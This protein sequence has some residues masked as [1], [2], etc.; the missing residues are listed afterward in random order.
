[1]FEET[2]LDKGT[3]RILNPNLIDYKWRVFPEL[4]VFEN[5][6]LESEI[7]THRF[8]A[9]GVGEIATAPGPSAVLMAVSNAIGKRI[10]VYPAT[11]ERILKA[12]GKI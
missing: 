1:M 11:P 2:I 10:T 7:S 4:P 6:V 9:V 8:K 12:L 5:A 3:G